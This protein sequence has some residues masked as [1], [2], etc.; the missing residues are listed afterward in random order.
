MSLEAQRKALVIV[1][2]QVDFVTGSLA[3][4]ESQA[5]VPAVTAHIKKF[6]EK[7]PNG[8]L[9]FTLDTHDENYLMTQEGKNL[10][11]KHCIKG[12]EGW[13]LIP[14]LNKY[15]LTGN[16]STESVDGYLYEKPAFGSIELTG[17]I[18][19][20]QNHL[21][22]VELIG[23]C[24]DICVI[25]NALLI[26]ANCPELPISINADCCAGTTP[27]RHRAAIEAMKSCQIHIQGGNIC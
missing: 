27:E 26:K 14:E 13:K 22:S 25:S 1:D 21:L 15:S 9:L 16:T 6:K 2:M 5:I 17:D 18:A 11:V 24:T 20:M 3:S 19:S 23:V 8:M 7:N 4:K 10:P 12:T